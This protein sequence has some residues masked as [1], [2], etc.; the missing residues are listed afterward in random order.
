MLSSETRRVEKHVLEWLLE[1]ENPSIRYLTLTRLLGRLG[2]ERGVVTS[3]RAIPEWKPI[4]KILA[5][6]RRNGSWDVGKTWYLPKYKSTLWQL[7]LLSQTGIDSRL[8]AVRKMCEYSF[9]FQD[10]DGA[11]ISG[12]D[13][14]TEV[15]WGRLAGCLNG[16]VV[17]SLCRLGWGRDRRVSRAAR[18]LASFQE[19]DGGWGCRTFG[20]HRK[21]KHSCFMGSICALEGLVEYSRNDNVNGLEEAVSRGCEFLLMHR[22]YKADH[23]GW[24]VIRSDYPKLRAPWLVGYNILRGLY[25][26][27]SAGITRDERMADALDLLDT[28]RG[29]DGRWP[30]EA[31]FPSASYAS[32]GSCGRPDKWSTLYALQIR[33]LV[34]GRG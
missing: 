20:Y 21:D 10:E 31:P 32:F 13:V 14:E 16:N 3:R 17:A 34:A 30:R 23:H 18:H 27:T 11:F 4:R 29:K 28:K 25:V 8:P 9:R 7:I 33:E 6:Q 19:A 15:D 12:T 26:L 24:K 2:N 1:E 22:L 5:H